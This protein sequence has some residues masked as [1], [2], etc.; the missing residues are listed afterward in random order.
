MAPRRRPTRAR[1][2]SVVMISVTSPIPSARASRTKA[3]IATTAATAS[4]AARTSWPGCNDSTHQTAPPTT[5]APGTTATASRTDSCANGR[6]ARSRKIPLQ[7]TQ[8]DDDPDRVG[9][10][11]APGQAGRDEG[12]DV[13]D[14]SQSDAQRDVEDGDQ[15]L[16][17]ERRPRVLHGVEGTL[18]D[19]LTRER[20]QA[21]G[22]HHQ[23]PAGEVGVALTGTESEHESSD[24]ETE[25]H[26]ADRRR[27][28]SGQSE[29]QRPGHL[30][31]GAGPVTGERQAGGAGAASRSPAT[32]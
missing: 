17:E 25:D 4:V 24:R 23:R 3:P 14:D 2:P 27:Q 13:D 31:R 8:R 32:R 16:E 15:H 7:P 5:T 9:E 11:V 29:P 10:R 28:Q 26:Q 22:Q 19:V 30:G 20:H 6:R 12:V 21:D 18:A 1:R